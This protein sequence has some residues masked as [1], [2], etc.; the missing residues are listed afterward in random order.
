MAAGEVL[1]LG[2]HCLGLLKQ[3]WT[4]SPFYTKHCLLSPQRSLSRDLEP[5][6]L[7]P[8]R[9]FPHRGERSPGQSPVGINYMQASGGQ[10]LQLASCAHGRG[11]PC[12]P[13]VSYSLR[14]AGSQLALRN[15]G[16]QAGSPGSTA[17][18]AARSDLLG[19]RRATVNSAALGRGFP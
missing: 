12:L 19:V 5:K 8:V 4:P 11:L 17:G 10:S 13:T 3:R 18:R 7:E 9:I 14:S 6:W 15:P 16:Q 1:K 2:F